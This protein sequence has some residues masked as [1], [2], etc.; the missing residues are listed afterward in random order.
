MSQELQ[1]G[2]T[3][4]AH[5][6]YYRQ[7]HAILPL[8]PQVLP[9]S[10]KKRNK[11]VPSGCC[12]EVPPG[13]AIDVVAEAVGLVKKVV[14]AH[15]DAGTQVPPIFFVT[16]PGMKQVIRLRVHIVRIGQGITAA[17]KIT[18]RAGKATATEGNA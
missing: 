13:G 16:D 11:I 1:Q 10:K 15:A 6:H 2:Y 4:T 8:L 14:G 18:R 17:E 3:N 5:Y 9:V 7:Y 12:V